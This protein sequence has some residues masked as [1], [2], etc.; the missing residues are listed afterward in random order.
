MSDDKLEKLLAEDEGK[1]LD[2]YQ[3]TKKIWTIG[4]PE[5]CSWR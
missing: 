1:R 4:M 3:D 2:M 5:T